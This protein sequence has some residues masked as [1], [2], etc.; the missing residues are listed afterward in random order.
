MQY[1]EQT[2]QHARTCHSCSTV[3][4]AWSWEHV[5]KTGTGQLKPHMLTCV[6]CAHGN[7]LGRGYAIYSWAK[8]CLDEAGGRGNT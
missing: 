2:L 3:P 6:F 4:T 1:A 7:M 5:T 8:G